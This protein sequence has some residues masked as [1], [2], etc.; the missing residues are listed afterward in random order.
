[1]TSLIAG[2]DG[3][4]EPSLYFLIGRE[5]L[6]IG[7]TS[8]EGLTRSMDIRL[9]ALDTTL[10][11]VQD[12]VRAFDENDRKALEELE[13]PWEHQ[14]RYEKLQ[15]EVQAL[16]AELNA[17]NETPAAPLTAY[18][19]QAPGSATDENEVRQAIDAICAMLADPAV[20][21]IF[22]ES[23]E[24]ENIPVSAESLEALGTR[25]RTDASPVRPG[26]V[27]GAARSFWRIGSGKTQEEPPPFVTQEG[28]P[29][30]S[31]SFVSIRSN[32]D[33]SPEL[34]QGARFSRPDPV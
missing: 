4:P 9:R 2:E 7:G 23:A 20:L 33:L 32:R 24:Q 25:D 30:A 13:R 28:R 10:A 22:R 11:D 3:L 34:N 31:L 21:A 14:E 8:D 15:A 17:A 27:A 29:P 12:R 19:L 18:D 1:M 26:R 5:I 6:P 16:D